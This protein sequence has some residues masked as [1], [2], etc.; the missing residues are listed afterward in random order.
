MPKGYILNFVLNVL[1]LMQI[2]LQKLYTL[3]LFFRT[4]RIVVKVLRSDVKSLLTR[5]GAQELSRVGL[6]SICSR[7]PPYRIY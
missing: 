4:S 1:F 2:F 7:F 5:T 6:V 3:S